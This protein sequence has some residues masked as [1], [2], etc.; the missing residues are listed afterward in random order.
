[1]R[2][3]TKPLQTKLEN[4]KKQKSSDLKITAFLQGMRESDVKITPTYYIKK[5]A[6]NYLF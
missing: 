3:V 1:M 4:S 5:V 2:G 6:S